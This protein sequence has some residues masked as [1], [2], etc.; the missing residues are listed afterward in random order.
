VR[1]RKRRGI[2]EFKEPKYDH[3]RRKVNLTPTLALFLRDYRSQREAE[4]ITLGRLLTLDDLV[5]C[6]VEGGSVDPGTLTKTFREI[7]DAV[8]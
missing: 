2:C 5:F 3:S 6:N 7:A 8:A 1:K 4:A